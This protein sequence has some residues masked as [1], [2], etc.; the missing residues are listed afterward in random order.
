MEKITQKMI[1]ARYVS[2]GELSCI[3]RNQLSHQIIKLL[4]GPISPR[5]NNFVEITGRDLTDVAEDFD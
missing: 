3:M 2:P 1:N 4:L 5:Y